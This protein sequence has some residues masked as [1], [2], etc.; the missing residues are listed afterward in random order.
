MVFASDVEL[1]AT[2]HCERK[3]HGKDSVV[4]LAV[5]ID[6]RVLAGRHGDGAAASGINGA[7]W[8][9][10]LYQSDQPDHYFGAHAPPRNTK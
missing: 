8:H 4:R 5:Y 2:T 9:S 3:D 7:Q 1:L 6:P 10:H